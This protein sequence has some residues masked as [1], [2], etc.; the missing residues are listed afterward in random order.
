MKKVIN[1]KDFVCMIIS[2]LSLFVSFLPIILYSSTIVRIISLILLGSCM[3]G[4]I[5]Y[6]AMKNRRKPKLVFDRDI[7]DNLFGMSEIIYTLDDKLDANF[8]FSKKKQLVKRDLSDLLNKFCDSI[9]R[10]A[11]QR[12]CASI[13]IIEN[14]GNIPSIMDKRI[15]TICRS[16]N[17]NHKRY[18]SDSQ[19]TTARNN[20]CYKQILEDN[21]SNFFI[22]EDLQSVSDGSLNNTYI[23]HNPN[24][25]QYYKSLIVVPIATE[26]VY[27]E[28]KINDHNIIYGFLCVDSK[29]TANEKSVDMIYEISIRQ[30][31]VLVEYIQGYNKITG[32]FISEI[33][34]IL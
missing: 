30:A 12:Y 11:N 2:V 23:N 16:K 1:Y 21:Q 32:G 15:V 28:K 4:Q 5:F 34:S 18:E 31:R 26:D 24:Y 27:N 19:P 6:Y 9:S 22:C 8:S 29:D 14:D 33:S 10:Y 13:K 3:I 20:T 7:L 17:S 25:L